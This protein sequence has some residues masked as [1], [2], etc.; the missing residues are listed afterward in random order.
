MA[1]TT[2]LVDL[3]PLRTR[4]RASPA[5]T[6]SA[7]F[8]QAE[9]WCTF[10]NFAGNSGSRKRADPSVTYA[11]AS[12]IS[13]AAAAAAASVT[14]RR[15]LPIEMEAAID[16]SRG[17][18]GRQ[19]TERINDRYTAGMTVG[20]IDAA[21][22]AG[23]ALV[24]ADLLNNTALGGGHGNG[25]GVMT[26][27]VAAL[28]PLG[29]IWA[30]IVAAYRRPLQNGRPS[31]VAAAAAAVATSVADTSVADTSVADTSVAAAKSAASSATGAHRSQP[32]QSRP[33]VSNWRYALAGQ[34]FR[35]TRAVREKIDRLVALGCALPLTRDSIVTLLLP[36]CDESRMS[37]REAFGAE[38]DVAPVT[39]T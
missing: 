39:L 22:A 6:V 28:V 27:L 38:F 19:V 8:Q 14:R 11:Y 36:F 7:L 17:T 5:D 29:S 4:S 20:D 31:F 18:E 24:D 37:E 25:G 10:V 35:R 2:K 13:A 23:R 33:A 1:A 32:P 16:A 26:P 3:T 12:P 30:P 15:P 21:A 34:S 9:T